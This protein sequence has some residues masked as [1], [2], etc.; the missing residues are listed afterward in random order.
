MWLTRTIYTTSATLLLSVFCVSVVL[1]AESSGA[2]LARDFVGRINNAILFPL[3]S[4]LVGV[5]LL[6]FLYGVYEYVL[7]SDN[8][9]E[10]QKGQQHMLWGIVGLVVMMSA[11]AILSIAANTFGL[12]SELDS[13]KPN[14]ARTR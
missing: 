11:M 8:D 7:N 14:S 9:S 6:V 1:A 3:I 4:L 5:A 13:A 10:R 12:G 2:A